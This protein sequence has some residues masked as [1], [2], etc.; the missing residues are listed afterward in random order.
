MAKIITVART[1]EAPR[2]ITLGEKDNLKSAL[3]MLEIT[4][5]EGEVLEREGQVVKNGIK[6]NHGDIIF[7]TEDDGN[8]K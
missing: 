3:K 8:G 5:K 2:Q 4:L 1:G 6:P 7:V